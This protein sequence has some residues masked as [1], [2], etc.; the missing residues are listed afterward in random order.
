MYFCRKGIG[1]LKTKVALI[2]FGMFTL[3]QRVHSKDVVTESLDQSGIV[4]NCSLPAEK[5]Q[6]IVKYFDS[7]EIEQK[8]YQILELKNSI[9]IKLKTP[10]TDTNTLNLAKRPEYNIR[11][12]VVSLGHEVRKKKN[13]EKFVVTVSKKEIALALMQHGRT[14]SFSDE[15]CQLNA[16]V[17]HIGV[18]QNIVAWTEQVAYEWPNGDEDIWNKKYWKD[19]KPV[20]KDPFHVPVNDL[21]KYSPKYKI[22]CYTATR[23][24]IAQGVLDY[25]KRVKPNPALLAALENLLRIDGRPLSG[26]EKPEMWNFTRSYDV[27][28]KNKQGKIL[29]ANLS[30]P[31][32][33]FIPG[34]WIY[35]KNTDPVTHEETGYEG[36]NS[37][38]LGRNF[39]NDYYNDHNHRYTFEEKL[40]EVYQWR[41]KVYSYS[42]DQ[43]LIK[44]L[45]INDMQKLFLTPAA[46]G[47]VINHRTFPEMYSLQSVAKKY[48]KLQTFEQFLSLNHESEL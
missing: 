34:D 13:V 47:L 32:D 18:R 42:R 11:D 28:E 37:I 9:V 2:F 15:N 21:V 4:F 20:T 16:L 17:E 44:P 29:A 36:S 26:L 19:G 31:K 41:N 35:I 45:S 14:T 7:I 39:L 22:Y 8:H 46:G 12:E 40:D 5:I 3:T 30:V 23:A 24:V 43:G 48:Q 6:E 27:R 10:E 33:N 38:Y 1:M 25:Y